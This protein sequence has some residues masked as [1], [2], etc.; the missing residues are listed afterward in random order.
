MIPE[1]QSKPYEGHEGDCFLVAEWL[2][3]ESATKPL[4]VEIEKLRAERKHVT[5]ILRCIEKGEHE[6]GEPLDREGMQSF[7][8][9]LLADMGGIESGAL[10]VM[11]RDVY[12]ETVRGTTELRVENEAQARH[13]D[14]LQR[15]NTIKSDYITKRE[16][17]L[18]DEN[19]RLRAQLHLATFAAELIRQNKP[20]PPDAQHLLHEHGWALYEDAEERGGE[21]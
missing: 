10:V 5:G 8:C 11:P 7:A 3:R 4:H 18:L 13:I 1:F 9:N 14:R 16:G 12:A 21:G 6:N 2:K 17:A 19:E 20:L 15:G